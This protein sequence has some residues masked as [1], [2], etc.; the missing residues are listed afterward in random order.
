[1][2]AL[3]EWTPGEAPQDVSSRQ[4]SKYASTSDARWTHPVK[5]R[6]SRAPAVQDFT[7]GG[8][9]GIVALECCFLGY[10]RP[11]LG[12]AEVVIS[13]AGGSAARPRRVRPLNGLPPQR[14]SNC[15]V[16]AFAPSTRGC[17]RFSSRAPN[18]V[19]AA[20]G[21][22]SRGNRNHHSERRWLC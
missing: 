21:I 22:I 4:R 19:S 16:Q 9:G 17:D 18:R 3:L 12:E 2:A 14:A 10:G 20:R 6:E 11:F 15:W 5:A 1:M 7:F 13:Q 8:C